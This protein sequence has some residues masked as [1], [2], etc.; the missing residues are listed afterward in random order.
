[1]NVL[2]EALEQLPPS[3]VHSGA[4]ALIHFFLELQEGSFDLFRRSALLI[5]REDALLEI[6]ARLDAA[7]HIV[8]CAKHAVEQAEFL[9]EQLKNAPISF[10]A[11]V[12]KIDDDNIMLL[13]VAMASSNA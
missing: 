9:A 7:E 13:P 6:D 11:L 4:D 3:V 8:G 5:D 12:Q 1:M 2:V 10:I